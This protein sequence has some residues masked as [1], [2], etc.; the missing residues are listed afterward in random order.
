VQSADVKLIGKKVFED[1]SRTRVTS[2]AGGLA[3]FFLLSVF[4]ML[5]VFATAL[6][7]LPIPNLFDKGID[8]MARFVP[9]DAM[10]LVRETL[11]GILSP[12]RGGLLSLGLLGA[13]WSASGGFSSMIDALDIAYDAKASRSFMKQR[14][15]SILLTFTVGGLFA[16][17]LVFSILGP[18]FGQWVTNILHLSS[19][20]AHVW[21]FL[22]WG[23]MLA[24]IVLAIEM[25]YYL[26]PNVKQ[27]FKATLPG[28]I[29]A[30][31]V[32]LL[33][34]LALGVYIQHFGSYNKTYGSIGAVVVLMLWLYVTSIVLLVGAEVN[35][36]LQKRT[37]EV[38]EGQAKE[39]TISKVVAPP[40]AA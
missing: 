25:L 29:L 11:K 1:I 9:A 22:R 2:V 18:A 23:V 6:G 27:T 30:T 17:G 38:L 3:Y 7:F 4:P 19:V 5:L 33:A 40:K 34:S 15:V 31:V 35:S 21:P 20:F 26:G 39:D 8:I 28:A 14:L 37:G 10:G 32:W 24:S 16:L 12:Q 13:I 36:E